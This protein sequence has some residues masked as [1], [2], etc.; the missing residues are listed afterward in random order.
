MGRSIDAILDGPTTAN[1]S[2]KGGVDARYSF[3]RS[4]QARKNVVEGKWI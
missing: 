2:N 1:D 4:S 3:P